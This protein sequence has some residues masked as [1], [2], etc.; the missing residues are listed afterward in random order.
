VDRAINVEQNNA[1]AIDE[2][3]LALTWR[4]FIDHPNRYLT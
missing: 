3:Q 2:S 1:A 4:E